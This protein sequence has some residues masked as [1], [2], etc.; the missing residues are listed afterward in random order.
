MS[1]YTT[2]SSTELKQFL[3]LYDI[4]ELIAFNGITAG[5]ENTNYFLDTTQGRYILTLY[6]A[7]SVEELPFFLGLMQ[8]LSA[9]QVETVT[10]VVDRQG[11]LLNQLCQKPAAIVERLAGE[12]L[13]QSDVTIEHCRLMGD[14]L[15]RFHLAGESYH[16]YRANERNNDFSSGITTALLASLNQQDQQLLQQELEFQ[17]TID[18]DALPS[19]ITHSDLFCDNSMFAHVDNKIVLSGI[20]DLYFSCHDAY[21]YDLAV[22]AND[23]CFSSEQGNNHLDVSRWMALLSAYNKVRALQKNEKKAWTAMLRISALRFWI[24]RLNATL[25][26][27]DGEM[28]LQKD[29]N[30]FKDKLNACLRDHEEIEQAIITL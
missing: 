1:V 11:Q 16:L 12:A 14:A 5:M 29:P 23:W 7:Y 9:H 28:V 26:P 24:L 15:A 10:P 19:G 30:E 18:W 20:I 21:I 6:E 4:G 3:A 8:H 25:N 2:V 17:Q 27:R 13:A 22:V